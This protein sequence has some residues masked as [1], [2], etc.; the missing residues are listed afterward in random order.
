VFEG[1]L[2]ARRLGTERHHLDPLGVALVGVRSGH[3]VR[4]GDPQAVRVRS[5]DKLAGKVLLEPAA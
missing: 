5:I 3:R 4:L 2:P 1:L